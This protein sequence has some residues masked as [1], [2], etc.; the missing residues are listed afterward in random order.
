MVDK[1]AWVVHSNWDDVVFLELG[2]VG[3]YLCKID[4]DIEMSTC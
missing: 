4:I 2:E 1:D 3:N